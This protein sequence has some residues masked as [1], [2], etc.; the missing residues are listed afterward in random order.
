MGY[1]DGVLRNPQAQWGFYTTAVFR[2][3]LGFG[4]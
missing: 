1:A 2:T 4:V 3:S